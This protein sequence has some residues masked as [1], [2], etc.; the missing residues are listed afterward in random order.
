MTA[1]GEELLHAKQR[2]GTKSQI[3]NLKL[4]FGPVSRGKSNEKEIS[5]FMWIVFCF[6]LCNVWLV[7]ISCCFTLS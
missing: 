1:Q 4:A 7:S 2:R 3:E 6:K 5:F